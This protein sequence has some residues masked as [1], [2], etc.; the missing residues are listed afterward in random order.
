[1]YTPAPLALYLLETPDAIFVFAWV[2]VEFVS[3]ASLQSY[4]F[5]IIPWTELH[6]T[7]NVSVQ[8]AVLSFLA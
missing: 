5:K 2:I 7:P 1:M 6:R 4:A 3:S 8:F